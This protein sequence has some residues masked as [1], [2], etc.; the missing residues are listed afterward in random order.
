MHWTISLLYS[1]Y[2]LLHVSAAVCHHQG[3]SWI[4]PSSLKCISNR[5][6]SISYNVSL[7]GLC[8][9]VLWFRLL[10]FPAEEL[11]YWIKEWY[12]SVRSVGC[13]WYYSALYSKMQSQNHRI[14]NAY[15]SD[16]S[17]D[18]SVE[19]NNRKPFRENCSLL[20]THKYNN[21]WAN[22]DIWDVR[23]LGTAT[24]FHFSYLMLVWWW[25]Q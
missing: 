1:I 20:N 23:A 4:R 2:R 25:T 15:L 19:V 22:T 6:Y 14:Q 3:A 24:T 12:N 9:G 8:T 11:V 21:L 17:F 13:L 16:R 18:E 5:W 7:C 10:S